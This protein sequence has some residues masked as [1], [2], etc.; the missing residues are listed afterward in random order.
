MNKSLSIII[1]TMPRREKFL[2]KCL[3]IL[4]GQTYTS[5]TIIVVC[6]KLKDTDSTEKIK[7]IIQKWKHYFQDI[8]YFEH[9][10]KTDARS[11]SL[12]IGLDA[13]KSRFVAFLDD[14]DK[15]YPTH[16]E[17]L[18]KPLIDDCAAWSYSDVILSKFNNN[19][20]LIARETPFKRNGYSFL[21][22]I[23]ANYIPIHSFVM[24]Y[25]KVKSI[26][27]INETLDKHEDYDFLL[28]LAFKLEPIY[29]QGFSAEYCTRSDGSNTIL[30]AG[31]TKTEFH[32]R[33]TQWETSTRKLNDLKRE[34]FGWWVDELEA[35]H[36]SV[37]FHPNSSNFNNVDAQTL[38]NRIYHSYTWE[39]IRFIKKINW[40]IRRRPKKR[41]T[42]PSSPELAQQELNKLLLSPCWLLMAPLYL[43]ESQIRFRKIKS[44]K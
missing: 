10:S 28:R 23:K 17:N 25:D 37:P 14:D 33:C 36:F 40:F 31:L 21:E 22:H 24:N 38:L 34:Q 6:Q 8:Q 16:Y 30:A 13:V 4:T 41:R 20:Q 5:I 15:V 29:V 19:D 2:D 44:T 26:G 3:F 18:I 35:Q 27:K 42:V 43:I 7:N 9:T 39:I 12:N 11:H 32:K 1:R